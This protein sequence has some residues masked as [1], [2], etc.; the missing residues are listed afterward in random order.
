[1]ACSINE[2]MESRRE[3]PPPLT[4]P[5]KELK[6][7]GVSLSLQQ[8]KP[9]VCQSQ[10]DGTSRDNSYGACTA[11][12]DQVLDHRTHHMVHVHRNHRWRSQRS[13]IL[14]CASV[15]FA[16]VV[17]LIIAVRLIYIVSYNHVF[18]RKHR[19]IQ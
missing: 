7:F 8:P 11:A 19:I 1:M 12:E 5:E 4:I 3:L 9:N 18:W 2:T 13:N 15:I 14:Y 17:F 16:T 6:I 10:I